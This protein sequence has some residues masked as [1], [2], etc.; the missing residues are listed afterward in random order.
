MRPRRLV[1]ALI[2]AAATVEPLSIASV[3]SPATKPAPA[4]A[5]TGLSDGALLDTL[6]NCFE[7][8]FDNHAQVVADRAAGLEPREG[9]GHEHI[10]CH[11]QRVALDADAG[12]SQPA[13]VM[14]ASY[15]FDGCPER[16][17][18]ERLYGLRELAADEQFGECVQMRIYQLRDS[19]EADLRTAGGTAAAVQWNC[20]DV[21]DA[22]HIPGADVFWRRDGDRFEG[23]MRTESVLVHSTRLGAQIVVRDDVA[24]W[25]DALWV[26]DRGSDTEGNYLYGNVRDVPYKMD[27]VA[28][29]HWTTGRADA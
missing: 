6:M 17:F 19:V 28:H 23:H 9:G 3:V 13:A 20:E 11:V 7:G 29:D 26:N 1:T 18:R 10:H 2:A 15:Y 27:R 21:A 12:A 5:S 8:H 16:I 24:L 14:L 25:R 22:M 4:W